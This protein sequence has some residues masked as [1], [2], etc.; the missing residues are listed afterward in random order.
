MKKLKTALIALALGSSM[1]LTGCGGDSSDVGTQGTIAPVV[2]VGNQNNADAATRD[3]RS[4]A[5]NDTI[6][7]LFARFGPPAYDELGELI[8]DEEGGVHFQRT[9]QWL[10]SDGTILQVVYIDEWIFEKTISNNVMVLA[11]Q[12]YF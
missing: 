2:Q 8:Y 4:I 9:V 10:Y 7:Q 1:F 6:E 12:R 5:Y 11:S 3:Y